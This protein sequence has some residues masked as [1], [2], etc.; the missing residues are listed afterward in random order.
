MMCYVTNL[1]VG[2]IDSRQCIEKKQYNLLHLLYTLGH[3][4]CYI[5]SHLYKRASNQLTFKLSNKMI[6]HV[7]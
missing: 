3:M 4:V 1:H 7:R 6:T 5:N 2:Y